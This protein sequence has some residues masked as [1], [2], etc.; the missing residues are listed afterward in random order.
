MSTDKKD[1]SNSIVGLGSPDNLPKTADG[2]VD[3]DA[4]KPNILV[5]CRSKPQLDNIANYLIRRGWN[6]VVT[7]EVGQAFKMIATFKPDFILLSVNLQTTKLAQLPSLIFQKFKVPVVTFGEA[8]NTR[9]LRGLQNIIA[10]YRIF[11][12][13]SGPSVHRR[14]KQILQQIYAPEEVQQDEGGGQDESGQGRQKVSGSP[15]KSR[16]KKKT[17]SGLTQDGDSDDGDDKDYYVQSE[18]GADK[19]SGIYHAKGQAYE[20]KRPWTG[21]EG[22]TKDPSEAAST[23][24]ELDVQLDDQELDALLAQ[25]FGEEVSP[26]PKS[27]TQSKPVAKS[28]IQQPPD[29]KT[30]ASPEYVIDMRGG[31]KPIQ[32]SLDTTK[33]G[34]TT[35]GA[36]GSSNPQT[37]SSTASEKPAAV[38]ATNSEINPEAEAAAASLEQQLSGEL[39]HTNDPIFDAI[40]K[41]ALKSVSP[42]DSISS[43]GKSV[44]ECSVVAISIGGKAIYAMIFV[45]GALQDEIRYLSRFRKNLSELLP[46]NLGSKDIGAPIRINKQ[47]DPQAVEEAD[48]PLEAWSFALKNGNGRVHFILVKSLDFDTNIFDA[49]DPAKSRIVPGDL[50]V[51]LP[52]GVDIFMYLPKNDKFFLYLKPESAIS[53]EQKSRVEKKNAQ[54]YIN[55]KDIK[56]FKESLKRNKSIELVVS[57]PKPI[58]N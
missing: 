23:Q 36:P 45:E 20:R 4:L 10:N 32:N 50:V 7:R 28:S 43:G 21:E 35:V 8:V 49:K 15:D 40:Y 55:K 41:I 33:K 37:Q 42:F 51:D 44:F 52:V 12:V 38:D 14:L 1:D 31:Q 54:L 29:N 6:T 19:S 58:A 30:G 57:H 16:F 34:Q 5:I 17:S 53:T 11:G 18:A 26:A 46:E 9:T 47:F 22:S 48:L 2:K 27:E 39:A 3:I 25:E 56:T 13:L 24:D